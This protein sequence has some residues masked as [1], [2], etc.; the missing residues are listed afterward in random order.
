MSRA[1]GHVGHGHPFQLGFPIGSRRARRHLGWEDPRCQ[2]V[3]ADAGSGEGR[4][5]HA[6]QVQKGGFRSG[7]GYVAVGGVFEEGGVAARVDDAGCISWRDA[8]AFG[9]ERQ[10]RDGHE[11]PA[12]AVGLE[13]CGP[14]L[15]FRFHKVP[16]DGQGVAEIGLAGSVE[17]GG[18]VTG[19]AGVVDEELDAIGLR[20]G[21][22]LCE[23]LDRDLFADI[24]GEATDTEDLSLADWMVLDGGETGHYLR[25]NLARPGIVKVDDGFESRLSAVNDVNLGAIGDQGLRQVEV[26]PGSQRFTASFLLHLGHHKPNATT[27]AGNNGSDMGDIEDL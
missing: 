21:D 2:H 24:C 8:V 16:G 25:Y 12:R 22:R 18:V 5:E 9:E 20:G 3:D 1:A 4:G 23:L 26:N 27:T 15:R 19:D 11:E 10:E 14:M 7:V 6:A 13:C 17:T